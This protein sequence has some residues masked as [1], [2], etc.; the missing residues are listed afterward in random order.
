MPLDPA[1]IAVVL[2][3][4]YVIKRGADGVDY[5]ATKAGKIIGKATKIAKDFESWGDAVQARYGS[6]GAWSCAGG[7][8]DYGEPDDRLIAR[9]R[10]EGCTAKVKVRPED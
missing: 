4:G 7:S 1:T 9:C 3:A 5:A 10:V 2:G 6:K 8:H